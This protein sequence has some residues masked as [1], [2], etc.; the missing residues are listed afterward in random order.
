VPPVRE[1]DELA[2]QTAATIRSVSRLEEADQRP[3]ARSPHAAL[4]WPGEYL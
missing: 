3:H 2:R 1:S 4:T